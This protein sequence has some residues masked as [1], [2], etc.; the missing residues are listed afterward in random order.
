MGRINLC[1]GEVKCLLR[2][3]WYIT[4]VKKMRHLVRRCDHITHYKIMLLMYTHGN[5]S[6][7][8]SKIT[9]ELYWGEYKHGKSI[10]MPCISVL[11][12]RFVRVQP[13]DLLFNKASL[14]TQKTLELA[15]FTFTA[16][17]LPL[18]WP[19]IECLIFYLKFIIQFTA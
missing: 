12:N 8:H 11:Q 3:V 19:M 10:C 1:K 4:F 17:L 9:M 7:K 5:F 2:N 13:C 16:Y 14:L 6:K 15:I 18:Y